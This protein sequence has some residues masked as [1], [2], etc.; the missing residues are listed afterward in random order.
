MNVTGLSVKCM[1]NVG[2]LPTEALLAVMS[3]AHRKYFHEDDRPRLFDQLL[4]DIVALTGCEG[5]FIGEVLD[6]DEP[7]PRLK[8]LAPA[9]DDPVVHRVQDSLAEVLTTRRAVLMDDQTH[10]FLGLPLMRGGQLVGVAGLANRPGGFHEQ[11]VTFLQPL[12]ELCAHL[13]EVIRTDRERS[14]ARA[15]EQEARAA[16]ERQKRL[17]LIGRLA[18]GVAHDMNNLITVISMQCD[19]IE[20]EANLSAEAQRSIA[21]IHDACEAAS[22]MTQRLNGLRGRSPLAEVRCSPR[23]TLETSIGVLRSVAGDHLDVIVS[24]HDD[25][26]DQHEVALTDSDLVQVMMNLVANARDAIDERGTVTISVSLNRASHGPEVR[27]VV[28]DDGP[29]IPEHL[30]DSLFEPFASDKGPGRGLGLPTV[31]TLVEMASGT[32]DVTRVPTGGTRFVID[33]PLVD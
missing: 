16:V 14:A 26:T 17:S 12:L 21:R 13:I 9:C 15:A 29:G 31:R 3:R 7:Q 20:M 30:L 32:I 33:L 8:A 1:G 6:D 11:D 4:A 24:L 19:L 10:N 27:I 28:D 2:V 22:S 25:V 5:G 23:A 18:S